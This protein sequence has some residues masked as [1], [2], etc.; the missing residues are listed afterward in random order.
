LG[1]FVRLELIVILVI[2]IGMLM[3]MVML[4]LVEKRFARPLFQQE[5]IVMTQMLMLDP[6]KQVILP[7]IGEMAALIIIVVGQ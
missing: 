7:F 4:Q 2:V 6:V 5:R 3:A 1:V